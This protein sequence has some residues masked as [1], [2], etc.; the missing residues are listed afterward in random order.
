MNDTIG[1]LL[2]DTQDR[3]DCDGFVYFIHDVGAE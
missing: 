2:F 3:S 1:A